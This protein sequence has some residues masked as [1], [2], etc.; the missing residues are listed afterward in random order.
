M[1]NFG[2]SRKFQKFIVAVGVDLN[3][4]NCKTAENNDG[5]QQTIQANKPNLNETIHLHSTYTHSDTQKSTSS[6]NSLNCFAHKHKQVSAI[7]D[8]YGNAPLCSKTKVNAQCNKL[9]DSLSI[10]DNQQEWHK[11]QT[12]R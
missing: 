11:N 4:E 7:A 9:K 8:K 1:A 6:L 5:W 10:Y 12:N 2:G 3:T